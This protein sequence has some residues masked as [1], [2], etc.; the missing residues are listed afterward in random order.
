MGRSSIPVKAPVCSQ[1]RPGPPI[2]YVLLSVNLRSSRST[3]YALPGIRADVAAASL[4]QQVGR[5]V[6]DIAVMVIMVVGVN[7]VF[8]RPLTP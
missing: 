3:T 2:D 6:L 4:H 8:W 1:H 7:V 5:L